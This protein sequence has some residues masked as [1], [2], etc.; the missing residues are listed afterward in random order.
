MGVAIANP[1][2]DIGFLR[3]SF[4]TIY[5]FDKIVLC[6]QNLCRPT[7]QVDYTSL[8]MFLIKIGRPF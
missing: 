8:N 6:N 3:R 7:M 4:K 5:N 2:Q 1:S